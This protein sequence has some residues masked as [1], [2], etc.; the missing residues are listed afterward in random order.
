VLVVFLLSRFRFSK[1]RAYVLGAAAGLAVSS[2]T[3]LYTGSIT[4]K[5]TLP[6]MIKGPEAGQTLSVRLAKGP[7]FRET[8]LYRNLNE[9][10]SRAHSFGIL[11]NTALVF[12]GAFAA[13]SRPGRLR[14]LLAFA[15]FSVYVVLHSFLHWYGWMWEP[16]MLF[17]VSFLLFL[18]A[19]RGAAEILR[20]AGGS[21]LAR[22]AVLVVGVGAL[23]FTL[24]V[25][26]PRRTKEEYK[27]YNDAP[28]GVRDEVRK[29]KLKDAL[30][31]FGGEKPYACYTPENTG[32][33][34]GPVVY[35]RW[36]GELENYK[37]FERFP[38]R[39]VWY[40]EG[41][42]TLEPRENFYR[43]DRERLIADLE[44]LRN[45]DV[46]IV[47]PWLRVAPSALVSTLPGRVVEGGEF[48]G[49]LGSLPVVGKPRLVVLVGGAAGM[50]RLLDLSFE[51]EVLPALG[52][53]GL[54]AFRVLGRPR[55]GSAERVPGLLMSCWEGT[56]WSGPVLDRRLVATPD[57]GP[58]AGEYRSISW[59]TS[60]LLRS[61]QR[62]AFQ[63]ESDDGS[64]LFVDGKLVLDNGLDAQ[65]GPTNVSGTVTL[66]PGPHE[67]LLKYFN[68]PGEERLT[69]TVDAGDGARPFSVEALL[70]HSLLTLPREKIPRR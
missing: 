4:G 20:S 5:W 17:D 38:R 57:L 50:A 21:R 52:Y 30:V 63:L 11:M 3:F 22:G 34:D 42:E 13:G 67:F 41:G 18:L 65:H 15:A 7:E 25:D 51:A 70:P 43:R 19:G 31:L 10:Q 32:G 40:T 59:E 33:F 27:K 60:V 23:G 36:R 58:C 9:L 2:L 53:E 28:V 24:F 35:A 1:W 29:R 45:Y 68:G 16:R 55:P 66:G 14:A 48:L 69:L 12:V 46:T 49:F 64:G 37:L 26:L 47:V 8:N 39:Q 44:R 56:E 61:E 62:L 54:M 6:Y